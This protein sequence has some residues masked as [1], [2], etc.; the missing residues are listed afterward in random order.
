VQLAGD[1][2]KPGRQ[3]TARTLDIGLASDGSTPTALAARE[4]V[5]LTIPADGGAPSRTIQSP[6]LDAKGAEG[7]GLT[8]AHFYGGV[9]FV[10]SAQPASRAARSDTLDVTLKPASGFED[11]RFERGVRFE[12]GQLVAT[13]AAARYDPDKGTLQL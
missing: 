13:S 5:Q 2:G 7:K 1:A 9:R 11:A 10:E 4:K 3:I 12:Q 8:S 6:N